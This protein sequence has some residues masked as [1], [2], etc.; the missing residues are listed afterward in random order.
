MHP[1]FTNAKICVCGGRKDC[2]LEP[3][4]NGVSL[5]SASILGGGHSCPHFTEEETEEWPERAQ[6]AGSSM[7][8][9]VWSL[10]SDPEAR[11]PGGAETAG[12]LSRKWQGTGV[13]HRGALSSVR[14]DTPRP[15]S[16]VPRALPGRT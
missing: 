6:M 7:G 5:K 9:R 2:T 12:P 3:T 1:D 14:E 15:A 10:S 11:T 8:S 4:K 16:R 13:G